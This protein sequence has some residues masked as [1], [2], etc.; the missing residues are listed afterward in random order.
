M[1]LCNIMH[2]EE[3]ASDSASKAVGLVVVQKN[4]VVSQ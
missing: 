3:T 2:L 1:L 4:V